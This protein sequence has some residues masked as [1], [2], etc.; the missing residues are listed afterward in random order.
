MCPGVRGVG[1]LDSGS[2]YW[3]DLVV[4]GGPDLVVDGAEHA[5]GGVASLPVVEDLQVLEDRISE[6]ESGAPPPAV[7]QFG[8]HPRR[9][10]SELIPT[11]T[12]RCPLI[13]G[14]ASSVDRRTKRL[15]KL[16]ASPAIHDRVS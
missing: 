16:L 8:L 12:D 3:V 11:N 9:R 5:E 7:E 15:L 2:G 13:D 10:A 1:V 6:F 14:L 4:E